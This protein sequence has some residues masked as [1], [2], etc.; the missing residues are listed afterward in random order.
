MISMQWALQYTKDGIVH[1]VLLAHD[2][3][4]RNSIKS[5]HTTDVYY[6]KPPDLHRQ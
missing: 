5:S 4:R 1:A 2:V 3:E 6:L